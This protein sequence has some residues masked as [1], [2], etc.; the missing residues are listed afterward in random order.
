MFNWQAAGKRVLYVG[1]LVH[2]YMWGLN[3]CI[4]VCPLTCLRAEHV[5]FSLHPPDEEVM[6]H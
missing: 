4:H 1:V 2:V 5:R 6:T 3:V